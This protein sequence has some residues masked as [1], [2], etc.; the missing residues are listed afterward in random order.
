MAI[1]VTGG[2]SGL[3]RAIAERFA[4]SGTEVFVNY[5]ANDEAAESTAAAIKAAGGI[6]YLIKANVGT[7]EGVH[8]LVEGVR[9]HVSGLDQLVHCA[10]KTATGPLLE[11]APKDLS[12]SVEVNALAL[13]HLVREALPLLGQGST[14][15]FLSSRGGR[16]VIPNYGTLG[17]S[18]AL[19]EHIVRYLAVELAPRGVRVLSVSPGAVDTTAFRAMFPDSWQQRLAAAAKANP[20]GRGVKLDDAAAAVE[21]LSH[22]ELSM[23][24]GQTITIDGGLSL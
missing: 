9:K 2:S 20:S 5:H 16:F 7:S 21:L 17:I 12:E 4:R 15:F 1:C 6:P 14:V 10:A 19:A 24:Q 13:I 3:G 23:M 22:P 11:A 18:K 8:A